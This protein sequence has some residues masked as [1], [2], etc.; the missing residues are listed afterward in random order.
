MKKLFIFLTLQA[1]VCVISS[2]LI[3]QMG[4]IGKIN[5][6][7]F[8]QEYRFLQTWWKTALASFLVILFIHLLLISQ[9]KWSSLQTTQKTGILLSVLLL[10][11]FGYSVYDFTW[12]S[13]QY[14]MN[15]FLI[16][17]IYFG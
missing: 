11:G 7:F 14:L 2:K 5:K 1:V 15:T 4:W 3:T 9:K 10:F 16:G 17:V 13:H 8:Y 6:R 12:T